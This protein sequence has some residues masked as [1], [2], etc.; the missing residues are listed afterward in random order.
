MEDSNLIIGKQ[1]ISRARRLWQVVEIIFERLAI[2]RCEHCSGCRASA[3][4]K[5][6][7]ANPANLEARADDHPRWKSAGRIGRFCAPGDDRDPLRCSPAVSERRVEVGS[8]VG[9]FA[10]LA[11]ISAAALGRCALIQAFAAAGLLIPF[12][13]RHTSEDELVVL[14]ARTA[15][16]ARRSYQSIQT[17]QSSP[18]GKAGVKLGPA[19][20]APNFGAPL[21]TRGVPSR[22]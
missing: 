4:S 15:P 22:A 5:P 8:G 13:F 21:T 14:A 17:S 9:N 12:L 1:N 3:F 6:L 2:F 19:Q 16:K 10:G 11:Q 20:V 18:M 7:A